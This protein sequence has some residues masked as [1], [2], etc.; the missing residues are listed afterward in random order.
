M[1]ER[2]HR[3]GFEDITYDARSG[4]FYVLI[5]SLRRGRGAFM[6]IVQE[7]DAGF[8]YIG[9]PGWTSRLTGRTRAWKAWRAYTAR[10]D[11]PA[12]AV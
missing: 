11:L 9:S 4:R 3:R 8:G 12:R 5:E 6:A 2:G 1:Q 7:Y 10:A